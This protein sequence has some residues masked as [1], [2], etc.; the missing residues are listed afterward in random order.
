MQIAISGIENTIVICGTVERDIM[1]M[2]DI[3]DRSA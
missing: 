3:F 1:N 2:I